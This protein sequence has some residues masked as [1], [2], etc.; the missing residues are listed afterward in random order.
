MSN[1][2]EHRPNPLPD[3]EQQARRS[4]VGARLFG[5]RY[6]Q[7]VQGD[8]LRAR[9]LRGSGWTIAGFGASQALRLTSNL[10]LTRLLFPEAFGLMA[11]AQVFLT[12]LN[13]LSDI[14]VGPSIV[15]N[16][17]G[18]DPDFLATAWTLQI[19]RGVVLFLGMCVIAYPVSLIYDEPMLFPILMLIGLTALTAGFQ[20]I[21][22]ATANRKM[23]LGRLTTIDLIS[24]GMGIF[25]M[26]VWAAYHPTVWALV[27]GGVLASAVR[28]GAGH[29][30]LP[31]A[32][33]RLY[34]ERNAASE[35]FHFG[36]WVF[37]ATAMTYFGGEGLRLIQGYIVSIETLG[38]ISI[39]GM[40]A[41]VTNLLIVRIGGMVLFPALAQIHLERP[42]ELAHKL[43]ESRTKLFLM[44]L[45]M[46]VVLIVFGRDLITLMYDDRYLAAGG[47]LVIMATSAAVNAQRTPFGMV[48]IATGDSFGHAVIMFVR[49]CARMAAVYIGFRMYGIEG[50]LIADIAAQGVIYPFEAWRLH[51]KK[52]WM[53]MFDLL[54][55]VGFL[56][57]GWL[58]YTT[59]P[60][61]FTG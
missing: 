12:G 30:L 13:M 42:E 15:Q 36:K 8:G 16:K 51:K 2:S 27:A 55:S 24:Q 11:L 17:R 9:A 26:V 59:G 58:S 45:P 35:I 40:L 54:V 32:G 56:M 38:I 7:M 49:A 23:S 34:F 21:G 19:I 5:S 18:D 37:V 48:L 3:G 33:N 20:S 41:L 52:L 22:M 6:A 14:G 53:P 44:S 57:L 1:E 46:F 31:S 25:T 43:R 4:G 60:Y 50:M 10:I 39:A 47:Y 61:L 29:R 28:V